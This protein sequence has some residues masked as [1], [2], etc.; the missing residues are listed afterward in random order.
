MTDEDLNN[1][2]A[3]RFVFLGYTDSRSVGVEIDD[4]GNSKDVPVRFQ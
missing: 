2:A 4:L 1:L 3:E